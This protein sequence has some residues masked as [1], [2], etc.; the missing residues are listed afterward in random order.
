MRLRL[1]AAMHASC[2]GLQA[3]KLEL[4]EPGR[5]VYPESFLKILDPFPFNYIAQH[6]HA[7]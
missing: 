5:E 1:D 4:V 6:L 2:S 7:G 3:L